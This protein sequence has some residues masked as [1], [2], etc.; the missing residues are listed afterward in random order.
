MID[1]ERVIDEI[2]VGF[3]NLKRSMGLDH[4]INACESEYSKQIGDVCEDVIQKGQN[5]ILL[6]GPSSSGKTT[7]AMRLAETF[8]RQNKATNI[9]SLDDFYFNRSDIPYEDD[10]TQDLEAITALDLE[11]LYKCLKDLMNIGYAEFPVFDFHTAKR[12][13]ST[14]KI[15]YGNNHILIIEGIHALNPLIING[16]DPNKFYRAYIS[17]SSEYTNHDMVVLSR[18]EIRLIRRIVRDIESRNTT[19]D[20]T[21]SMW[22]AVIDGEK[23]YIRP[24]KQSADYF[25]NS[26]L[27]Y[28]P[29]MFK[30]VV[31]PLLN[32]IPRSSTNWEWG[33]MLAEATCLFDSIPVSL[34][35][36]RSLLN[37]F[38]S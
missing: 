19:A 15:E 1:I 25:I 9:V 37:E 18:S 30:E 14:K 5:I 35:P 16:F 23:K 21:M 22:R 31:I 36:E 6:S 2:N 8:D 28:E 34:L 12:K 17:V 4:F 10:G 7:T 33:Q 20:E 24:Y 32:G 27:A 13:G 11:C 26:I 3:V 38:L 29:C